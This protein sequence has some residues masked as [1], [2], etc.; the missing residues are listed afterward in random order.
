MRCI[1][2]AWVG[3]RMGDANMSYWC[4]LCQFLLLRYHILLILITEYRA[5]NFTREAVELFDMYDTL[6]SWPYRAGN[7]ML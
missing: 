7:I 3:H 1:Q 5:E 4:V 6:V 2:T